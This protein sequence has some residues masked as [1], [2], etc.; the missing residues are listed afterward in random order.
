MKL[1]Y[2][3][4]GLGIGIAVTA[5]ILG[6]T[7]GK[8]EGASMTDAQIIARAKELGMVERK[9]L[10]DTVQ[11]EDEEKGEE[12]AQSDDASG[13]GDQKGVPEGTEEPETEDG[14]KG[15]ADLLGE[16][17]E[18]D[19]AVAG[20]VGEEEPDADG[21]GTKDPATDDGAQKPEDQQAAG[22]E[23][24]SS[25]ADRDEQEE[26]QPNSE[27]ETVRVEIVRGDSSDTVSRKLK[28]AGL[29][30]DDVAYNRFLCEN[31]YDKSILA[32]IH[33]IPVGISES[34]IAT[35]ITGR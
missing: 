10:S 3:L 11:S 33:E 19:M 8:S 21:T 26:S 16:G 29:V 6:L 12:P 20:N 30:V 2:Y 35:L 23:D 27:T 22:R 9:V 32:G 34:E 31:G 15:E 17:E 5:L 25:Q 1:K 7:P 28:E 14:T 4:R 13:G 18:P 24:E